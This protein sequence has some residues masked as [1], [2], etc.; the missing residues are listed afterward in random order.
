[1]GS[2]TTFIV[3]R[4]SDDGESAA[5]CI[6]LLAAHEGHIM[7]TLLLTNKLDAFFEGYTIYMFL[8]NW[9]RTHRSQFKGK[10]IDP[11]PKMPDSMSDFPV[12]E[13]EYECDMDQAVQTLGELIANSDCDHEIYKFTMHTAFQDLVVL[14]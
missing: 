5:D 13:C 4:S 3:T 1:M 11:N 6:A 7:K 10:H 2:V 12:P 8:R 9:R 14:K